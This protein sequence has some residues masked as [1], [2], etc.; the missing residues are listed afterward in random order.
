M[1]L[2]PE[3]SRSVPRRQ[4]GGCA[5]DTRQGPSGPAPPVGARVRPGPGAPRGCTPLSAAASA[6]A[7]ALA[8]LTRAASAVARAM[9]A[10]TT[11]AS[12]VA[13]ALASAVAWLCASWRALVSAVARTSDSAAAVDQAAAASRR[14]C[15]AC[16]A[17]PARASES[18][19]RATTRPSHLA[20][21]MRAPPFPSGG[22]QHARS[23]Q[24][25]GAPA[26]PIPKSYQGKAPTSRGPRN[27]IQSAQGSRRLAPPS[28]RIPHMLFHDSPRAH[29]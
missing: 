4:G 14:A 10:P 16:Q 26:Q 6:V 18:A 8:S 24:S 5:G 12:V 22:P 17:K 25:G 27:A 23:C 29:F 11:A 1:A 3:G 21:V 9:A 15:S 2:W 20:L 7:R 13:C 19:R 28:C